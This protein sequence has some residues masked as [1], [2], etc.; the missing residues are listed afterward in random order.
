MNCEDA[1]ERI[2]KK[3]FMYSEEAEKFECW[4]HTCFIQYGAQDW[5]MMTFI[6]RLSVY[7]LIT[8]PKVCFF[9]ILNVV[10]L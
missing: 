9:V 6:K 7:I 4:S 5:G 1:G 8:F 2:K 10:N 3:Y